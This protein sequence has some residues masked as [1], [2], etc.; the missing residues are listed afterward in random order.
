MYTPTE[1]GNNIANEIQS[2]DAYGYFNVLNPA[3]V[4]L[5]LDNLHTHILWITKSHTLKQ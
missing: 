5:I 1:H 3:D 2:E 4:W